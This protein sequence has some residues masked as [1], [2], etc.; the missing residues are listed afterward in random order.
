ME[1]GLVRIRERAFVG[2][3]RITG[4]DSSLFQWQSRLYQYFPKKG[5]QVELRAKANARC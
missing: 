1:P 3:T 4:A 2:K 5:I